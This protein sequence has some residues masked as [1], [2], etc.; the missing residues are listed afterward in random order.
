VVAPDLLPYEVT[1][2][3]LKKMRRWPKDA[4]ILLAAYGVFPRISMTLHAVDHAAVL[5]LAR[6]SKLTTYDASY[7]WL[8]RK[9]G[10]E[11]LTFD[12][13]LDNAAQR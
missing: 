7:L 8:A 11:L 13:R 1:S 10:A 9:L 6:A 12:R 3:C 4:E 2:V 5:D